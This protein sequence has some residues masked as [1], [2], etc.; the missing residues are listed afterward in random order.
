MTPKNFF[1]EL[2]RRNVYKVAVVYAIVGWLVIQISSTV[3]PTFHTPEWVVQTLVVVVMLGFPIALILAWAFELTPEGIKRAEDVAP[4]ESITH[5]T[6][7]KLTALIVFVAIVA[8]VLLLLQLTR[9]KPAVATGNSAAASAVSQSAAP[10]IPEKSIAVLPFQ[11]LSRDLDNAFFASGIQDEIITAL[12]K[13]RGLKVISR[14]STAHY[15]SSPENLP[16]IARE[17]RAANILEGSVQKAGDKVHINVQLVRADTDAHLWAQSYDRGLADIFAVEAEVARS[18][19]ESLQTALS[20]EEKAHVET[21]PMESASE[22]I[23]RLRPVSFRYRPEL[24]A[25]R[26]PQF[27]LVAEEVE[28]VA[29]DLVARDGEGKAYTVRYEAVNAML[30]NEFLKEHRKVE[31]QSRKEQEQ[32]ATISELKSTVARQQKDFVSAVAQQQKVSEQIEL[33]KPAPQVAADNQ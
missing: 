24:D 13:V 3:L 8:A 21:K 32:E 28:K 20:P 18:I 1:V 11:N 4:S 29:P 14:T 31:E 10:G 15:Q 12:A 16:Q 2:K 26:I 30:L 33:G 7:Q 5:R 27:G 22:A 17:L 23:L 25:N 19:A 9:H 6:G